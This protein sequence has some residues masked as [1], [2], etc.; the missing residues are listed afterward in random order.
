MKYCLTLILLALWVS[1]VHAQKTCVPL[2]A[3]SQTCI[4]TVTVTGLAPPYPLQTVVNGV[5]T[6]RTV[7][8]AVFQDT[9]ID[10]GNTTHVYE[11]LGA[12]KAVASD[13][14]TTPA[15]VQPSYPT[16][17]PLA[18]ISVPA[19]PVVWTLG[20]ENKQYPGNFEILRNGVDVQ[21]AIASRIALCN[22]TIYVYGRFKTWWRFT[23]AWQDTKLATLPVCK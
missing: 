16:V 20:Q 4:V 15:V 7:A 14:W 17:P 2:T 8:T 10:S 9:F 1:L 19:A 6:Q 23:G 22:N 13:S 21:K 12:G 11:V 5:T 18:N 3:T